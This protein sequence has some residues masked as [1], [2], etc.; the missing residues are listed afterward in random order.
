[1]YQSHILKKHC[2]PSAEMRG[3]KVVGQIPNTSE[4]LLAC[5][6]R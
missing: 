1:M 6:R 5:D 2:K 3:V 4:V